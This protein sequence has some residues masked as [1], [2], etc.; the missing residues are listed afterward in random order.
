MNDRIDDLI[1]EVRNFE[2]KV[3]KII[4]DHE[5]RIRVLE[6]TQNIGDHNRMYSLRKVA[7]IVSMLS[8]FMSAVVSGVLFYVLH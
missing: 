1:Q 5:G 2:A 3:D 6:T 7:I 4:L 8:A